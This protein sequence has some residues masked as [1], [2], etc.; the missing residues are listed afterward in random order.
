L[1][2]AALGREENNRRLRHLQDLLIKGI[3]A[4]IPDAYLNTDPKQASPAHVNFAFPG[5]EGEAVLMEL[6]LAGICVSTGSACASHSLQ[7]SPT[8]LAMGVPKGVVHGAIRMTLGKHNTEEEIKK[9][10]KV[11]P[12]VVAKYR[13]MSP[14]GLEYTKE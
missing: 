13:A 12:E 11:L 7:S 9:V 4:K 10:L 1:E 14:E 6:D 8:L 3:Q 2:L 5:A